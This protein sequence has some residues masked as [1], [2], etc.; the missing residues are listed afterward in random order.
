M[1]LLTREGL[2][3]KE[4]LQVVK[5][6]LGDG[7]YVYV[8]QMTGRERD[9]FE[10]TLIEVQDPVNPGDAP[11]VIQRQEDFRAKL[12]VHTV[13]DEKGTLLLNPE[14]YET[15]STNI[16]AR[17]LDRIIQV[18]QSLN[19]ITGQDKENLLKN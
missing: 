12:A 19:S 6:D 4:K 15:L 1:E 9:S 7:A 10:R 2:L 16:S 8:R 18:A 3:A 13:C 14:D 17:R 5:V 11:I